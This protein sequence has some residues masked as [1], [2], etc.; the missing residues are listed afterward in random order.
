MDYL[1][2]QGLYLLLQVFDSV[3]LLLRLSLGL[4]SCTELFIKL[5]EKTEQCVFAHNKHENAQADW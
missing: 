4:L 3:F 5:H 2:L 1:R